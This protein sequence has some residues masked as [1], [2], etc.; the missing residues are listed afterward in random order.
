MLDDVID[1]LEN[2]GSDFYKK[3]TLTFE[4][5]EGTR[6]HEIYKEQGML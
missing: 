2:F 3:K 4:I 5:K 1:N 6:I